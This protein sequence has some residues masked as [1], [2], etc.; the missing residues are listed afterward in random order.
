MAQRIK[1]VDPSRADEYEKYIKKLT[2]LHKMLSFS[3]KSRQ[4]TDISNVE[5]LKN[6]LT[7]FRAEY[8]GVP[9]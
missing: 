4:T 5:N 7:E 3:M 8:F 9:K 6:L 1:I 2:L